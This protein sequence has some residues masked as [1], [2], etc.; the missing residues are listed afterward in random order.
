MLD[1]KLVD[2]LTV[3]RGRTQLIEPSVRLALCLGVYDQATIVARG[4]VSKPGDD[5]I[6]MISAKIR[7]QGLECG[8]VTE[9]ERALKQNVRLNT[10][11]VSM[12]SSCLAWEALVWLLELIR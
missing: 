7:E 10:P 12:M 8:H 5:I 1:C 4:N 3:L 9:R 2:A 11:M 6:Q